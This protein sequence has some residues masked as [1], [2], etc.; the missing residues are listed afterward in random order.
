MSEEKFFAVVAAWLDHTQGDALGQEEGA[1]FRKLC[2]EQARLHSSAD[3]RGLFADAATLPVMTV[4]IARCLA[5]FV[6]QPQRLPP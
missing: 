3:W 5:P 1:A 2:H 4:N 6:E